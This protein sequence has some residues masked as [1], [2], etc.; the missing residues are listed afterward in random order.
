MDRPAVQFPPAAGERLLKN[1]NTAN[2]CKVFPYSTVQDCT[3]L[4]I[5]LYSMFSVLVILRRLICSQL[6]TRGRILGRNPDKSLCL[7]IF[8]SS[9]SHN[10]LH[11]SSNSCNLLRISLNSRNLLHIS[12]LQ[13]IY[14]VKEKGGKPDRKSYPLPYGLRNPLKIMPR[15]LNEIV[16]S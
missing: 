4:L 12:T 2:Q 13:L 1:T 16:C 5:F 11:I 15:N 3:L 7:K 8:I 10:L 14:A 6:E 9:N